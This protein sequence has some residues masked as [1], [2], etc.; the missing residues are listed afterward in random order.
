MTNDSQ[1]T[2]DPF[3]GDIVQ[4]TTP[5]RRGALV[6][7]DIVRPWGIVGSAPF[8]ETMAGPTKPTFVRLKRGEFALVGTAAIMERGVLAD[9]KLAI[10]TARI[11]AAERAAAAP[12]TQEP[13]DRAPRFK[14]ELRFN[15]R[16]AGDGQKW[17][18]VVS[19]DC[20]EEAIE[21]A[22]TAVV[23]LPEHGSSIF[24]TGFTADKVR[25]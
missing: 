24:V 13:D 15:S 16:L 6:V 10:E 12:P 22:T 20:V 1:P 21:Q 25:S 9:R 4:V 7:V 3:P 19:A 8:I 2:R 5:S 23:R 18:G 17:S 11:V 14:V